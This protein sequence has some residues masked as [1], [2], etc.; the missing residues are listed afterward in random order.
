MATGEWNGVQHR[1]KA[2]PMTADL[3]TAGVNR[4]VGQLQEHYQRNPNEPYPAKAPNPRAA[5]STQLNQTEQQRAVTRSGTVDLGKLPPPAAD[6]RVDVAAGAARTSRAQSTAAAAQHDAL[7]GRGGQGELMR[8][9]DNQASAAR[10]TEHRPSLGDGARGAGAP[11]TA[12][13]NRGVGRAT[14]RTERRPE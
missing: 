3:T 11:A 7:P 13:I 4:A 5:V 14:P 9:L 8:F 6:T 2:G 10:A 1:P 12:G